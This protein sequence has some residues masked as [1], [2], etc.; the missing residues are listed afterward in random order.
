[1]AFGV[2]YY[3]VCFAQGLVCVFEGRS[4]LSRNAVYRTQLLRL[5]PKNFL[6]A[7]EVMNKVAK[8]LRPNI[9]HTAKSKPGV[10]IRMHDKRNQDEVKI[11][12]RRRAENED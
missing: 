9:G 8:K 6:R 12:L 3:G 10:R 1:M 11:A 5:R 7:G 4:D 2:A